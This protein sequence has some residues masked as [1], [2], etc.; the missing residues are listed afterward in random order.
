MTDDR[1]S[2]PQLS[3]TSLPAVRWY[4]GAGAQVACPVCGELLMEQ[5]SAGL[6]RCGR[7]ERIYRLAEAA[8]A[9]SQAVAD[10][11]QLESELR[12]EVERW[13]RSM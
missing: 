6:M 11:A 5:F 8:R 10:V 12:Q 2:Q 9:V 4:S 3:S 7:C 13:M 1:T